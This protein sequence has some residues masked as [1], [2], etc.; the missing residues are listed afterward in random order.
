[1]VGLK[2]AV[3]SDLHV[4]DPGPIEARR[5]EIADVLLLRAIHRINRYL[6]PD[7]TVLLGDLLD[8]GQAPEADRWRRTIRET[9][10]LLDTP[11][12]VLPG[13]HDGDID[14]FYR[15]FPRPPSAF[16][17]NGVR[18]L[19]FFDPEEP[20][21]NARRTE[22]DIRRL[23][24]ERRAHAGPLVSLQHVPL[25]PP[26]RATCPYNLVNSPEVLR[27]LRGPGISLTLS[28][29]EHKGMQL[30]RQ[31]RLFFAATP[32]L[33]E[34]PFR[35]WMIT[36]GDD[37][38]DVSVHDER[39]RMPD[40]LRLFDGHV[41]TRFAYCGENMVVSRAVSLA[42]DFGL[43]GLGFAEHSAHLY[44][45]RQDCGR[46]A[47]AEPGVRIPAGKHLR[48]EDYFAAIEP[49]LGP[50]VVPGLEADLTY[51]GELVLR[52]KDRAR[53]RLLLAAVHRLPE[54]QTPNPDLDKA[55]DEFLHIV[56]RALSA[57]VDVLA[58]PF[59]VFR[60]SRQ[61]IPEKLYAPTVRLLREH[62]VAAEI[63][64]HTNEPPEAFVRLCLDAGVRLAFGSD[65]H[66]LYEVGE[67]RPHLA[68]LERC[69]VPPSDLS[70]ILRPGG[71][72]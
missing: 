3:L 71:P 21:W 48:A 54:L 59:R 25:F 27:A 63:N 4:G 30:F 6:H 45:N 47:Y 28:G 46:G 50:Q 34:V 2:I 58:H 65:S 51:A 20:G 49:A 31:D 12:V 16:T 60:R 57:G 66:N 10:D 37:G 11:V 8:D 52:P 7:L 44:W 43:A 36:I 67:F 5:S 68:L 72:G 62:G 23:A 9:L 39:L 15:D 26:G 40:E 24:G 14:A 17:L 38:K 1:M 35:F 18:F 13:N 42:R 69:G 53:C 29:H 22:Q 41:H 32:A 70:E 56:S 55:A 33:C 61:P 19:V 64:Y